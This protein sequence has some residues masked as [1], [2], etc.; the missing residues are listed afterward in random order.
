MGHP[1]L[2]PTLSCDELEEIEAAQVRVLQLI[3]RHRMRLPAGTPKVAGQTPEVA[4]RRS[5]SGVDL[6]L[7]ARREAWFA[8]ALPTSTDETEAR[9]EV[10]RNAGVKV[11]ALY[12]RQFAALDGADAHFERAADLGVLCR[13]MSVRQVFTA[14][15]D[16][17]C[18]VLARGAEPGRRGEQVFREPGDV[19]VLA[20]MYEHSWASSAPVGATMTETLTCEQL[21]A[22][23]LMS[24]GMKD[25]RIARQMDISPRTLSRLV[26]KAMTELGVR[27]RFEAGMRAKE[28]GLL[29]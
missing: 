11:R 27:S 29:D 15:I 12:P 16:R 18:V 7:D 1:A 2:P 14:V 20:E 23:Q 4:A 19:A 6:I 5:A 3:R 24:I 28:L 10:L 25:D 21:T 8:H 26:A 17:E 13:L 9:Y 22:L